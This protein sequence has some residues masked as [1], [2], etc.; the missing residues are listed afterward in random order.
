MKVVKEIPDYINTSVIITEADFIAEAKMLGMDYSRIVYEGYPHRNRP[1]DLPEDATSWQTPTFAV[2]LFTKDLKEMATYYPDLGM[3]CFYEEPQIWGDEYL[4]ALGLSVADE[5]KLRVK[6][7]R[8]APAPVGYAN[9]KATLYHKGQAIIIWD[10]KPPQTIEICGTRFSLD[11]FEAFGQDGYRNNFR[12]DIFRILKRKDGLV[13]VRQELNQ[14]ELIETMHNML[15]QLSVDFSET[16]QDDAMT[17][18]RQTL[19]DAFKYIE[20]EKADSW[21]NQ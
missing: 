11:Y 15:A 5:P 17:K 1:K 2:R 21:E 12:N 6:P 8:N 9:Q 7:D 4:I 14:H 10:P 13:T 16:I 18:I 20:E 3:A 19:H